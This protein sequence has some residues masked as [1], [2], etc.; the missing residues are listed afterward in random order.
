[1]SAA[2]DR[3]YEKRDARLERVHRQ[4]D[5]DAANATITGFHGANAAQLRRAYIAAHAPA[6]AHRAAH[7]SGDALVDVFREAWNEVHQFRPWTGADLRCAREAL[8]LSM[9]QL[10]DCLPW[11]QSRVSE[12]ERGL[13]RVPGWVAA[14]VVELET[15]RDTLGGRM[16]DALEADPTGPLVVHDTDAGY[17]QAHPSDPPIP[18]VVQRIAAALAAAEWEA[19]SGV[20]PSIVLAES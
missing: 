16:L 5:A 2:K 12:A 7:A 17:Q 18:A 3:G 13:R 19:S 4:P 6:F 8:G 15:A 10:A 14:R 9:V 1:M 20:R 11:K